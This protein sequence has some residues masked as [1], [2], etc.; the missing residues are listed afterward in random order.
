MAQHIH[1]ALDIFIDKIVEPNLAQTL[2]FK[3]GYDYF[4]VELILVIFKDIFKSLVVV[5]KQV[6][7]QTWDLD[8]LQALQPLVHNWRIFSNILELDELSE[9]LVIVPNL[10]VLLHHYFLRILH[11]QWH[12]SLHFC[13]QIV[14]MGQIQG[15]Q[16]LKRKLRYFALLSIAGEE[17]V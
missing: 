13:L 2:Q 12:N 14:F 15:Y 17:A 1:R 11:E 5:E 16:T 10:A 6:A 7:L 3:D 4:P 9:L 8:V